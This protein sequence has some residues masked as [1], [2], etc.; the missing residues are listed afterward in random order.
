M[1]DLDD[2]IPAI[3]V[4]S[5]KEE[6]IWASL[7]RAMGDE[8]SALEDAQF[9][10]EIDRL[11]ENLSEQQIHF[12]VTKALAAGDRGFD[13]DAVT[14]EETRGWIGSYWKAIKREFH[15]LVCT[16]SKK[17]AD[18]RRQMKQAAAKGQVALV[19]VIAAAI[20][21]TLG[22]TAGV[23]TPFVSL[24]LIVLLRLG[25]EAYCATHAAS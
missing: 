10:R 8:G 4:G 17:F 20:G 13:S 18:L 12:D 23:V 14:A 15:D 6:D 16:Q 11:G 21:A 24:C 5:L 3:I 7:P 9:V 1:T 25:K 22:V 2:D 19:G